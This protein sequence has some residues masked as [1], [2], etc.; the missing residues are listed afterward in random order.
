[1]RK[2]LIALVFCVGLAAVA[3]AETKSENAFPILTTASTAADF[4]AK[5]PTSTEPSGDAVLKLRRDYRQQQTSDFLHVIPI[6]TDAADEAFSMRVWSWTLDNNGVY[7]PTL[8][9]E[10]SVTLGNIDASAHGTDYYQADTITR[11]YG[12][13]SSRIISAA[14]DLPAWLVVDPLGAHYLEFDF[15]KNTAAAMNAIVRRI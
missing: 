8:L 6:G 12:D 5:T 11:T 3:H 10:V 4:T 9:I 7:W 14:N 15:D 2:T 1:M 13:S